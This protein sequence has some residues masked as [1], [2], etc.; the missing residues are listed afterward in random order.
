MSGGWQPGQLGPD[1]Q[2][3][4]AHRADP[5]GTPGQPGGPPPQE[6][7]VPQQPGVAHPGPQQPGFPPPGAAQPGGPQQPG[8]PQPGVPQ[9]GQPGVAGTPPVAGGAPPPNWQQP[10]PGQP[11]PGQPGPGQP[12]TPGQPPWAQPGA[13]PPRKSRLPLV[14]ALVAV[15]VVVLC[16]GGGVGG[17]LLYRNHSSGSGSDSAGRPGQDYPAHSAGMAQGW[18]I[19]KSGAPHRLEIFE[20]LACPGCKQTSEQIQPT[21][22]T[23]VKD[24]PDQWSITYYPVPLTG[25]PA[26]EAANAFA[27]TDVVDGGDPSTA[28]RYQSTLFAHQSG[29]ETSGPGPAQLIKL[30]PSTYRDSASFRQCVRGHWYGDWVDSMQDAMS[31][32]KLTSLPAVFLDGKQLGQAELSST[33][34]AAA[35][36]Q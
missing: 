2:N 23:L 9:P 12:G 19:G 22:D 8:V 3:P 5:P 13:R 11:A 34:F 18:R 17:Y 20:D 28:L 16:G 32:R 35:V 27:C 14:L 29:N 4:F 7:G 24:H 6:S 36:G 33:G 30:A 1:E 10:A 26:R 25:N 31:K 21:I 15:L